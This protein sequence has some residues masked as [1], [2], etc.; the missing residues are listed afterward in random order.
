[1][2][3][4]A[5]FVFAASFIR[6]VTGFG[7]M[8]VATPLLMLVI[9]PKTVVVMNNLLGIT[10]SVMLL[11]YMRR[12]IDFRRGGLMCLG[13]LFGLPLGAYLLTNLDPIII[14]LAVAGVV[15]P[16]SI[17]LLLGHSH[18]FQRE[19][20]WCITVGFLGGLLTTSTSIGGPPVVLFMLNQGMVKERFVATFAMFT[21]FVSVVGVGT[22]SALGLVTTDLLLKVAI[23]LPFLWLGA[24][25]GIKVLPKINPAL[26]RK[27]TLMLLSVTASVIIVTVLAELL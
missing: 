15:I 6:S 3:L 7:Y 1:V 23:L 5:V 22:F 17:L 11:Y 16:F 18:R 12:H 26:F 9:E 27:I 19:V 2:V 24:H 8:L 21:L 13:G 20:P 4:A 10:S 25:L 14:K